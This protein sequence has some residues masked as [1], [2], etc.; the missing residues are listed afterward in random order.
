ML[1]R[2]AI[3][4]LALTAVLPSHAAALS[5]VP[6]TRPSSWRMLHYDAQGTGFNATERT[7]GRDTVFRLHP[8][9][10]VPKVLQAVAIGRWVFAVVDAARS[11][12]VVDAISG[13]VA[14]TV[15]LASLHVSAQDRVNALAY[16]D[17][18]VIVATSLIVAA[19]DPQTGRE[20]WSTPGGATT[21]VVT[22]ATVYTG[23]Y[24]QSACGAFAS[25]AI[26]VHTGRVLWR[27][28]GNFSDG[29]V[30]VAGRLYQRWFSHGGETRVYD[31]RSGSLV[32]TL[33]LNAE[34]TGDAHNAYAE[35]LPRQTLAG[36]PR[37]RLSLVR[38]DST[39]RPVWKADLG[40]PSASRPVLAYRTLYVASN[41]FH[42]GMVA[43]DARNGKL[44][45]GADIGKDLTLIAANHLVFALHMDSSGRVDVV[46]AGS[47]RP[48]HELDLGRMGFRGVD[49]M[50]IAGGT[51]YLVGAGEGI[52]ALRP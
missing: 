25:Y 16:A 34:W 49:S 3:V 10:T 44:L 9:W 22:G 1:R 27:H 37:Q 8:V 35:V 31:Q 2:W 47:G 11:I 33:P 36:V 12:A 51:L 28:P 26:D 43:V 17:G 18:T 24:C 50:M 32:A 6:T 19:V 7:I 5:I 39:G 46:D 45:W 4:L 15:T 40:L 13:K 30:L 20:V 41:R 42:P 52:V 48:V 14:R 21:L 38:I 29:P 23:K